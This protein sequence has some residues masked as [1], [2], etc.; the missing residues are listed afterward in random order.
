MLRVVLKILLAA[1]ALSAVWAFV[2]IGGHTLAER[3]H[4]AGGAAAF[5]ER[6]FEELRVAVE[7]R[8]QQPK[9]KVPRGQARPGGA[10][11]HPSEDHSAS[12]R[13]ALNRILTSRLDER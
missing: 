1:A 4:R 12:D 9:P 11:G 7:Q 5:A 3:F 13:Q 2:P 10:A 8:E 6:T